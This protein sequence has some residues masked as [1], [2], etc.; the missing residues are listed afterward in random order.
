M[1]LLP[2]SEAN[3]A[4]LAAG[5]DQR[6]FARIYERYHQ[7]IYRYC[8]AI[9]GDPHEAQDAMHST[10][11]SALRALP[12][13]ERAVALRPWLYRVAR[14]EAI[15]ILRRRD[16]PVDPAT[17]PGGGAPTAAEDAEARER[18]R[19]LMRD[20]R[21]L[22]ERHR[23]ALVMRELSGLSY[24]EIG[25]ALELSP[26]AARQA[27]YEA[28]T[29]LQE[30]SEG[31]DMDCAEVRRALSDRDGRRLRGRRYRAHLRDCAPCADFQTGIEARREDLAA[32]FPPLPAAA[33]TGVLASLVG[34]E[35]A[36]NGGLVGA[37][38][39]GA[40][41]SALVGG[42][43]AKVVATIVA[44][45]AVGLG[46]AGVERAIDGPRA[47][48][49]PGARGPVQG[50]DAERD[51][52]LTSPAG[53]AGSGAR[54]AE[55]RRDTSAASSDARRRKPGPPAHA[56]SAKQ[57][58]P[59]ASNGN[60]APPANGTGPPAVVPGNG[61]P[62]SPPVNPPGL[63]GAPPAGPPATTPGSGAGSSSAAQ[64]KALGLEGRSPGPPAGVSPPGRPEHAGPG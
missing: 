24:E 40:S 36:R 45:T 43:A 4:R 29:A 6:A 11:A 17:L 55:A 50:D 61:N 54:D 23:S 64:G 59:A 58:P 48:E 26:G 20:L 13:K 18:L 21:A 22:G 8:Q 44:A 60:G 31:R 33:A 42:G 49:S 9:L 38:I 2:V 28:R 53:K 27:V 46:A 10:M 52:T 5:G 25:G 30:M 7:E 57:K 1:R 34:T 56:K 41:G 3:L 62:A 14:N 51:G 63:G 39:G 16:T 47:A 12:S 35:A 19:R 15:S 37:L 32:L